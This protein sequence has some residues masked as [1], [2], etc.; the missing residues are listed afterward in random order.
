MNADERARRLF[1][2]AAIVLIG[3]L[4]YAAIELWKLPWSFIHEQAHLLVGH[5][6]YGH[7]Y[8]TVTYSLPDPS[9]WW[10]ERS[11]RDWPPH[12]TILTLA[13]GP[14]T[15]PLGATTITTLVRLAKPGWPR[16]A[17]AALAGGVLARHLQ[18]AYDNTF[19]IG[20]DGYKI[21]AWYGDLAFGIFATTM[22]M[23]L[24]AAGFILYRAARRPTSPRA[25]GP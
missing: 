22:L 7:P 16:S 23:I 20:S 14:L 13:A 9:V 3:F 12:E 4:G 19:S 11:M 6:I 1:T 17:A 8:N 5:H 10:A 15:G 21:G 2:L 18:L 24:T 25:E